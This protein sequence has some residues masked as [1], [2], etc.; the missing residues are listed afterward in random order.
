MNAK[1]PI[2]DADECRRLESVLRR[3]GFRE[4]DV[5]ACNC[6]SWHAPPNLRAEK[7]EAERDAAVA[8]GAKAVAELTL[9][10]ER[11]KALVP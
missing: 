3:N 1:E 2:Y 4:C 10:L 8:D 7:A 5:A 6:G 11:L 9:E